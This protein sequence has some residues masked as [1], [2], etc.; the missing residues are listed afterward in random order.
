MGKKNPEE[1]HTHYSL[2]GTSLE[3]DSTFTFNS[4]MLS[5]GV[6]HCFKLQQEGYN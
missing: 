5:E 4:R 6:Q 2:L 1:T 3:R